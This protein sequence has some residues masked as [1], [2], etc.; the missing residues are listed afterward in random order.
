MMCDVLKLGQNYAIEKRKEAL[1]RIINQTL[2]Y[3]K[4]K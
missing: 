1:I 2:K 3:K 4:Q